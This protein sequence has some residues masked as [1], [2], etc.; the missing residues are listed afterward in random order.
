M[1]NR[2][3]FIGIVA[4]AAVVC[5][6]LRHAWRNYGIAENRIMAGVRADKS[7]PV[8]ETSCDTKPG[9]DAVYHNTKTD[10][11]KHYTFCDIAQIEY[12]Y[13]KYTNYP[14]LY[15]TVTISFVDGSI[16]KDPENAIISGKPDKKEIVEDKFLSEQHIC[17][18]SQKNNCCY[19]KDAISDCS[20]LLK[21]TN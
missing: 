5:L 3:L 17:K 7:T 11:F 14:K 9:Y 2:K 15:A 10:T 21:G 8:P 1:K 4:V 12:Y 18:K 6:N 20:L 13:T 19:P 16:S